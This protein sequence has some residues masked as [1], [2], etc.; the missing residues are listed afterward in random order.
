MYKEKKRHYNKIF[1]I[2]L[3]DFEGDNLF[4]KKQYIKTLKHDRLNIK[5]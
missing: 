1:L 4:V 3:N 5:K 2:L